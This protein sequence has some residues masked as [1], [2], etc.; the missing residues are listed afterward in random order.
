MLV[1][2]WQ[3]WTVRSALLSARDD[4]TAMAD[5]LDAGDQ[6]AAIDAA[7]RADD[8]TSHADWHTHTPIWWLSQFIP[9]VGD[10][11]EAVRTVSAAAHDLTDGVVSP[12]VAAGLTPDDFKPVDGR[13]PI[14]PLRQ[15]GAVLQETAP[16]VDEVEEAV[17]GLETSGLVG[18]VRGPVE[19]FTAMLSDAASISHAAAIAAELLP[20]MLGGDGDRTYLLVFQN[21]AEVRATGGL[22]G[23]LGVLTARDGNLSMERTFKPGR[24]E[25]GVLVAPLTKAERELFGPQMA[26]F[27]KTTNL[28][29]HW[30]RAAEL[31][32]AFWDRSGQPPLDGVLSVDPVALSH[33]VEYTGPI[34][35][36][37]G[38]VLTT[39]N[40]VEVL[41]RDS[42]E[43]PVDKQ[44]VFFDKAAH[45][46]FDAV[47]QARGSAETLVEALAR[48]ID[49]RRVAV[50]SAHPEEQQLLSGEDVANELPQGTSR[51]EVGVYYNDA[52]AHKMSYYLHSDVT[53]TPESC[54]SA[55]VQKL[56]V[57]VEI[58]SSAPRSGLSSY[59]AGD[60]RFG[61]KPY[62]M[63][64]RILLVAPVDGRIDEVTVDDEDAISGAARLRGHP[65]SSTTIELAPEEKTTLRYVVYTGTEHRDDIHLLTT[66]LA[67]GTGG[68]AFVDSAC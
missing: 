49:E 38:E 42:Y 20:G 53:V 4:L 62:S 36:E 46:I 6:D 22:Q 33:L 16:R 25:N 28:T 60:G 11:V 43:L 27:A 10:E 37:S 40:T 58:R 26:L 66:P 65:T 24:L 57:E 59:V 39:D 56:N 23:T 32:T 13:I 15:A 51:P 55:G 44:D 52:S 30:P 1:T 35:L 8:A 3:A 47:V 61:L 54:S 50:W 12:V 67:D 2:A 41:L 31:L 7:S 19:E 9:L 34:T 68:E 21:N 5:H 45:T 17:G 14:E 63:R 29:P 18:P 48:G 64:T